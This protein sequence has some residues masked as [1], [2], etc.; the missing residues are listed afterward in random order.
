MLV[1]VDLVDCHHIYYIWWHICPLLRHWLSVWNLLGWHALHRNYLCNRLIALR[2]VYETNLV[3]RHRLHRSWTSKLLRISGIVLLLELLL[4]L[5]CHLRL[6]SH[7]LRQVHL[8]ELLLNH[9]C[10]LVARLVLSHHL[11]LVE[12]LLHLIVATIPCDHWKALVFCLL[13]LFIVR[14]NKFLHLPFC[15]WKVRLRLYVWHPIL[16]QALATKYHVAHN[17][18][19]RNPE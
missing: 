8:V 13:L 10:I 2:L 16:F 4:N 19:H 6:H 17:Y 9:G 14:E 5:R 12:A 15:I 7:K 1:L 18:L 11:L 3:R